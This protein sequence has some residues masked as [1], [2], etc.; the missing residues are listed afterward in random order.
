MARSSWLR[1]L[2]A[3]AV[4]AS[5]GACGNTSD[6]V[7]DDDVAADLSA[8]LQGD[9]LGLSADDA[10]CVAG[11][12]VDELGGDTLQDID[13][14]ADAP[15]AGDEEAFAAAVLQ[16]IDD[17]NVDLTAIDQQDQ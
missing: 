8:E 15:P 10:D 2:A 4:L 6:S 14:T 13:L 16:A 11:V 12:L 3:L 17:C 9:A 7:D 1:A 5:A